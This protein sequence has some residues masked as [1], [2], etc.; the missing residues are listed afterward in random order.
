MAVRL[1]RTGG[2]HFSFS[3]CLKENASFSISSSINLIYQSWIMYYP[4]WFWYFAPD[5]HVAIA[6]TFKYTHN[7]SLPD[8][9]ILL[10]ISRLIYIQRWLSRCFYLSFNKLR[11]L[12][13][14]LD[15]PPWKR[16]RGSGVQGVPRYLCKQLNFP[17]RYSAFVPGWM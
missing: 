9:P 8:I 3:L 14:Y 4:G 7:F 17:R 5:F 12:S 16:R 13:L 1:L 11:R 6:G 15:Q 10:R 2:Q